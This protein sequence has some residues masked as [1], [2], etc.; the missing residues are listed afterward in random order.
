MEEQSPTEPEQMMFDANLQQFACQVGY[1]CGLEWNHKLT[2]EEAYRRIR[3]L[4]R[5]LKK[6]RKG[7][8]IN[9]PKD[10]D[11]EQPNT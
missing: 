10:G 11:T 4:W 7:L 9:N 6:S 2:Q 8:R 3:S 1:I 5:Q